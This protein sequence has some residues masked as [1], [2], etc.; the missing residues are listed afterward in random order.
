M[1][2]TDRELERCENK[3]CHTV[4]CFN[5]SYKPTTF[6]PTCHMERPHDMGPGDKQLKIRWDK[7][8]ESE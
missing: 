6:C 5:Y 1:E 2:L 4:D 3:F 7:Q 8:R